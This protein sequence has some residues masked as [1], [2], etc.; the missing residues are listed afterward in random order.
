MSEN[1]RLIYTCDSNFCNKQTF[2]TSICGCVTC[3]YCN[4]EQKCYSHLTG[5]WESFNDGELINV[6][7]GCM[8]CNDNGLIQSISLCKKHRP[9]Q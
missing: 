9:K 2:V 3:R 8:F 7:C 4:H 1:N 6:D 5:D